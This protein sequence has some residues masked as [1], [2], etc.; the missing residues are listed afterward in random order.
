MSDIG[1]EFDIL[2]FGQAFMIPEAR[3]AAVGL[4][5]LL[6]VW[7]GGIVIECWR[8]RKPVELVVPLLIGFVLAV[9]IPQSLLLVQTSRALPEAVADVLA[10]LT[11]IAPLVWAWGFW[12][13][14]YRVVAERYWAWRDRKYGDVWS[15]ETL[16]D[17]STRTHPP[18][19]ANPISDQGRMTESVRATLARDARD[20]STGRET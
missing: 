12:S 2:D 14:V 1:D 5:A 19:L 13:V 17:G 20:R 3:A 6:G 15:I 16:P 10:V 4:S 9:A 11:I 18:R 7:C 8:R